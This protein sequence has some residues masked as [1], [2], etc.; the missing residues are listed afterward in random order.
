MNFRYGNEV[1]NARLRNLENM[2]RSGNRNNQN[3]TISG[4]E[5]TVEAPLSINGNQMRLMYGYGLGV[6][7]NSLYATLTATG[8]GTG[9][10]ITTETPL[11]M[12]GNQV[13]LNYNSPLTISG[14]ALT[15]NGTAMERLNKVDTLSNSLS[16]LSNKVDNL[17]T[18]GTGN[19]LEVGE[20]FNLNNGR[21]GLNYNASLFAGSYYSNGINTSGLDLRKNSYFDT[22]TY[23]LSL[24]LGSGLTNT[25]GSLAATGGG[26][27]A[28][29]T[30]NA[31]LSQNGSGVNLKIH[32]VLQVNG[33]KELAINYNPRLFTTSYYS[34]GINKP[35]LDININSYFDT[36]TYGLSLKLGGGLRIG[37][38][39][40]DPSNKFIELEGVYNQWLPVIPD[41]AL[42]KKFCTISN[43]MVN[44]GQFS[45]T[46][47]KYTISQLIAGGIKINDI[48]TTSQL[49]VLSF[50]GSGI[51]GVLNENSFIYNGLALISDE[52]YGGTSNYQKY[53]V[54]SNSSIGLTNDYGNSVIANIM[55]Y[56]YSGTFLVKLPANT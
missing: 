38:A 35:G 1:I 29:Y 15:L 13:R 16:T 6:S 8:G 9:S 7:N 40:T 52:K 50:T 54:H 3:I 25:G 45:N 10:A 2:V 36:D 24:K 49:R 42:N 12:N 48:T 43:I 44:N 55:L 18:G 47:D 22:D 32:S 21:L 53:F 46:I 31:P 11:S 14:S 20:I 33:D 26:I 39:S 28:T 41:A 56:G 23:G 17:P 19:N 5:I 30:F 51:T 34:S 37:S 4:T 27:G